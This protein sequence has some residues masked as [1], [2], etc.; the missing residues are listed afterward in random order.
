MPLCISDGRKMRML[1]SI[2][3]ITDK[4]KVQE[5]LTVLAT[6]DSLSGL[7]NRPEFL[8]L[9]QRELS[10]AKTH[11]E[12]LAL[13]MIDLDLFKSINDTYGHAAG[14]KVIREMGNII[15]TG[16][17]KTDFAGRLGGEEFAVLLKNTSLEE[18]KR[19]AEKF[20]E[21]VSKKKV[22]YEKR[23]ISFTVSIGVASSSCDN[24]SNIED[25]LKQADNA[26]YKAKA[27]GRNCVWAVK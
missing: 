24:N 18:A 10:W 6:T 27:K 4:K 21:T 15:M 17:R 16:F 11:N 7:Y 20:R 25:I 5:K 26:L 9:A 1:K 22:V 12:K 8:K 14:D 19:V 3:D 2:R 13:L 23:K